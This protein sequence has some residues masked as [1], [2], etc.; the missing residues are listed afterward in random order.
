[1]NINIVA[2]KPS[3]IR[4]EVSTTLGINIASIALDN[5]HLT[6]YIHRMDEY[7]SGTE[8]LKSI[9]GLEFPFTL[10]SLIYFL[11]NENP[12]DWDCT[13]SDNTLLSCNKKDVEVAW[14]NKNKKILIDI[15]S[16]TSE[17]SLY[18]N[19]VSHN[20]MVGIEVFRIPKP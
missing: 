15:K 18:I 10:S 14:K 19:N 2:T 5:T 6:Y 11:F 9:G 17:A 20:K 1:M 3:K 8:Q 7:Y 4:L 12:G 13:K 16:K